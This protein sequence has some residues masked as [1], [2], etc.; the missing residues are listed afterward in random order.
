M[1]TVRDWECE[2]QDIWHQKDAAQGSAWQFMRK[3]T[4]A[5]PLR[6]TEWATCSNLF[7]ATKLVST[8]CNRWA[9][10]ESRTERPQPPQVDAYTQ[11][12]LLKSQRAIQTLSCRQL[13]NLGALLEH[14]GR[15]ECHGCNCA[16]T[17]KLHCIKSSLGSVPSGN[18][19]RRLIAVLSSHIGRVITLP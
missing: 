12:D 3:G 10:D 14:K 7:S 16:K 4:E 19:S 8:H 17:E 13:Q 9:E 11:T 2:E 18:L 1:G 5:E 15:V 6:P